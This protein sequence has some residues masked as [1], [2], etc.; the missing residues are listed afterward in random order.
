M[1]VNSGNGRSTRGDGTSQ[2]PPAPS[3]NGNVIDISEITGSP[4][5]SRI[6]GHHGSPVATMRGGLRGHCGRASLSRRAEEVQ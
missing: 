1:M 2:W 4:V 3:L 6:D 5:M